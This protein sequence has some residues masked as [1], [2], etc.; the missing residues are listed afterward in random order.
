MVFE[1]ILALHI[2]IEKQYPQETAFKLLDKYMNGDKVVRKP[3]FD[4]TDND[5]EDVVKLS[6]EGVTGRE[7][8]KYY[9]VH[10]S[11]ICQILKSAK[12]NVSNL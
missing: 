11:I 6:S 2:A 7:I 1:N 12:N 4:W 10:P 9:S 8:S 5:K 3:N